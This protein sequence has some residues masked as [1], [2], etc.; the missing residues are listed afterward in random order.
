LNLTGTILD[1]SLRKMFLQFGKTTGGR[2]SPIAARKVE[3]SGNR[4]Q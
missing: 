1:G 2:I 3:N 4:H